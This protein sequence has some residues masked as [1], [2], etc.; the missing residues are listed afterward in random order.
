MA[1]GDV[2]V[3]EEETVAG[4]LK[5]FTESGSPAMQYASA[6]GRREAGARGLTNSSIAVGAAAEQVMRYGS[7]VAKTDATI[8]SQSNIADAAN[9]TALEQQRLSDVG[10]MNR[11]KLT[12]DTQLK[13]QTQGDTA[14]KERLASQIASQEKIATAQNKTQKEIQ[15]Q[16]DT[17]ALARVS[18][19]ITSTE[20]IALAE[21]ANKMAI[22]NAQSASALAVAQERSKSAAAIEAARNTSATNINTA[23]LTSNEAVAAARNA[24]NEK[25]ATANA[26]A[27]AA[28]NQLDRLSNQNIAKWNNNAALELQNM[29]EN[30]GIT[31]EYRNDATNA[32]QGFSN[33]IA[34]IDTTA[35][36]A[37]QTEQFNRINEAFQSRMGFLNTSRISDLANKGMNATDN[38]AME[39]YTKAQQV[40]MTAAELD[41]LGNVPAG[42]AQA[43]IQDKGLA[44][45]PTAKKESVGTAATAVVDT[46]KVAAN[47]DSTA[48][49]KDPNYGVDAENDRED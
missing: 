16:A 15:T 22:A 24:S 30:F 2:K 6:L 21:R 4:R 44:P 31:S 29:K 32:W 19:Q 39:A 47:F 11:T 36:P 35:S 45:L 23:S 33:G 9:K 12:T 26:A 37:S 49:S 5:K 1:I 3:K 46:S 38:D 48:A 20:S 10:A 40:G 34:Q 25:I 27:I 13:I 28:E 18:A 43:W 8:F 17:A 14:A 42:T 41:I 7:D